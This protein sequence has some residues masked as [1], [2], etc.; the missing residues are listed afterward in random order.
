MKTS[1]IIRRVVVVVEIGLRIPTLTATLALL[2][3]ARLVA[4]LFTMTIRAVKH[5]EQLVFPRL[6]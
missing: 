2:M 6:K 5:F 1:S 3:I 4:V